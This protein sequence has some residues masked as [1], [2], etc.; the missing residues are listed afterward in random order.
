MLIFLLLLL[1]PNP[2]TKSIAFI[3]LDFLTKYNILGWCRGN[4]SL[5]GWKLQKL[6]QPNNPMTE[7]MYVIKRKKERKTTLLMDWYHLS[8]CPSM[9]ICFPAN[10]I[11]ASFPLQKILLVHSTQGKSNIVIFFY[12]SMY[13]ID[14]SAWTLETGT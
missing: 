13:S 1:L 8:L 11:L 12:T 7:N 2:T 4:C 9:T 10:Q 6:H 5:K 14:Q 3:F